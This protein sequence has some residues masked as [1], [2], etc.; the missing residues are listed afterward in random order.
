MVRSFFVSPVLRLIR[1]LFFSPFFTLFLCFSAKGLQLFHF[2]R[3]RRFYAVFS[4]FFFKKFLAFLELLMYTHQCRKHPFL[5]P[6]INYLYSP[7]RI[8]GS[9]IDPLLFL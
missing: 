1:Q 2:F 4:Y 8:D 6:L 3:N 7:Q 5:H 9:P